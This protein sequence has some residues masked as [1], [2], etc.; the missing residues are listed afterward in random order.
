MWLRDQR[1]TLVL[2]TS[3]F[4]LPTRDGVWHSPLALKSP[5]KHTLAIH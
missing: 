3:R 1:D 5:H 2:K 4:F